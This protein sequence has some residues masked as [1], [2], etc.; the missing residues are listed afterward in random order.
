[1][2]KWL[3]KSGQMAFS[4][5]CPCTQMNIKQGHH[6]ALSCPACPGQGWSVMQQEP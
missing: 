3:A 1:M 6:K 2:M 4:R 5:N